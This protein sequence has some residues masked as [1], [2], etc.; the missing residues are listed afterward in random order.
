[1]KIDKWQ[2]NRVLKV[3]PSNSSSFENPINLQAKLEA[4]PFVEDGIS[5]DNTDQ[6][7]KNLGEVGGFLPS[8][9]LDGV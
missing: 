2:H 4:R 8:D 7:S 3:E 9:L 5:F 1:M 6:D